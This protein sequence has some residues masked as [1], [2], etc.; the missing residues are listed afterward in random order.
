MPTFCRQRRP[1]SVIRGI[2]P[3]GGIYYRYPPPQVELVLQLIDAVEALDIDP[4]GVAL[5]YW[6]CVHDRVSLNETPRPYTRGRHQAWL[7]RLEIAP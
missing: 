7:R 5:G 2:K 3:D 6:R 1:D 4:A